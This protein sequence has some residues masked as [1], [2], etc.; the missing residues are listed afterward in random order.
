MKKV[1]IPLPKFGFDPTEAAVPWLLF[2]DAGFEVSFITPDGQISQA[3]PRMLNGTDLCVFKPIL[4]ARQDAVI[5][6]K[7]MMLSDSFRRP[8]S[9][10]QANEADFDAL[11]LP[12]GH[13]KGVKEYLESALLQSLV[14]DFFKAEKPVAAICHG[15]VLLARSID[16]ATGH[17]V[18]HRY[19][20][21]ALLKSQEL[22]GYNLTRLWLG[23]YYLTYP[24]I[25]V[26]DEVTAALVDKNHFYSGPLALLRDS[27]KKLARGFIVKDRHYVSA[28]WPGDTYNL[29]FEFIM[30]INSQ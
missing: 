13:D 28:R 6:C 30:M 29:T 16:P 25:T 1:L 22:L 3:D 27:P 17:S 4:A 23:D 21:T 10:Q 12:G 19:K 15:V 14:V 18:I 24:K 9:Y 7:K 5:A 26:E 2:T 11:L 20:T 8:L